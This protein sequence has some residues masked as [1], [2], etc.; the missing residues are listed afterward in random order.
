MAAHGVAAISANVT[1]TVDAVGGIDAIAACYK[2]L[3]LLLQLHRRRRSR[4]TGITHKPL[5][6]LLG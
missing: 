6:H 5:E 1:P 4:P 3:L 2:M